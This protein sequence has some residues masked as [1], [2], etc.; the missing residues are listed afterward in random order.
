MVS[1]SFSLKKKFTTLVEVKRQRS[2]RLYLVCFFLVFLLVVF[3]SLTNGAISIGLFD[4]LEPESQLQKTVLYEIRSPRIFLAGFVGASLSIAG[5][6]LQGLFRNPLADPGL[7]GVSSGAA[8]GAVAVIV[9]G[10]VLSVNESFRPYLMPVAAICG[11]IVVTSFL[12]SFARR[13]GEFNVATILLLGI[14]INSLA[15]VG[16][17]A[18]QYLSDDGEL[19]TLTFWM[20][21]SF[22]RSMWFTALPTGTIILMSCLW[23]A[24]D[25]RNLDLLQ[26]GEHEAQHLGVSVNHLKR[27]I[28]L[29]SATAVG[30]G[31]ALAGMIGF[32]GL[33]VPHLV[34]LLGGVSHQ[35]VLPAS[36]LL[37]ASLM[38]LADLVSRTIV[39][40]AEVPVSLVTSAIGAPFFLWL[41]SRVRSS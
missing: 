7:I 27:R 24:R 29:C 39:V 19:R 15:T 3:L 9:F 10:S 21:G 1:A 20:M 28:I 32:V 34:R 35:Y 41:I 12:Y 17:G 13:Y 8:L 18:F 6:A 38:M 22:S 26:L 33:V 2:Q 36:A 4:F 31:V 30:A 23:L 5:A 16:I 14:A 11:A 40:P 37:G 25:R